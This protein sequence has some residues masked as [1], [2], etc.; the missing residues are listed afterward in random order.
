[1]V[2]KKEKSMKEK[3]WICYDTAGDIINI[4]IEDQSSFDI[5]DD[6]KNL[7]W[8]YGE[9]IF[10]E[11]IQKIMDG[12]CSLQA[13]MDFDMKEEEEKL[14]VNM[15]RLKDCLDKLNNQIVKGES[16]NE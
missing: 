8:G 11:R 3:M 5:D 7:I 16:K 13:T 1:M 15:K 12:R 4:I 14:D 10:V 6:L 9:G 2:K